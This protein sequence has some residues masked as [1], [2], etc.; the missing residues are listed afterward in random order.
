MES[1][2]LLPI[3][4]RAKKCLH[5]AGID[6]MKQLLN[7]PPYT[8]QNIY[9]LGPK[10]FQ[11]IQEALKT[12]RQKKA[13]NPKYRLEDDIPKVPVRKLATYDDLTPEERVFPI[14]E[15]QMT[16][17]LFHAMV[18]N[19]ITTLGDML[20]VERNDL[21]GI[22]GVGRKTRDD[23]DTLRE[24]IAL[25][26]VDALK[27]MEA[28]CFLPGEKV[29]IGKGFDYELIDLLI[30]QYHLKK[31]ALAKW[32]GLSRQRIDQLLKNKPYG[33]YREWDKKRFQQ[34]DEKAILR[35]IEEVKYDVEIGKSSYHLLNNRR[36]DLIVIEVGEIIR[37]LWLA[38]LPEDLQQQLKERMMHYYSEAEL[39][40]P[41][42]LI[43]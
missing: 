20:K 18:R 35:M 12:Y 42:I 23:Y 27:T 43:V 36:G 17:R 40:Y 24:K 8:L 11:V 19:G 3:S 22:H 9:Y 32:F 10:S 15:I 28:I 38:D 25:Y 31:N 5:Q 6:T 37:A 39:H 13:K 29:T 33:R 4:N 34:A 41:G 26:G 21:A 7:T 2:D 30:R 14:N 1:I 16:K